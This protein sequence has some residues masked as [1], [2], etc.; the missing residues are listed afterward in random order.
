MSAESRVFVRAPSGDL[1]AEE[2]K[3]A[4]SAEG[5][6]A[7]PEG[8]HINDD[9]RCRGDYKSR[10]PSKIRHRAYGEAAFVVVM[11]VLAL[12]A[13][14]LTWRGVVADWLACEKC[15]HATLDRYAYVL[16]GGLLGGSLFGLKYIYKVLAHGF[17]NEDRIVWRVSSPLLSAGFA[18]AL[19]VLAQAGLFGFDMNDAHGPASFISLGFITGYFAD[20]ASRKMQEIADI[21]FGRANPRRDGGDGSS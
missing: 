21:V 11:L 2:L 18:F 10:Y 17:W 19:G 3:D 8:E 7:N 6:P 4:D 1:P 20:G 9:E 16:F 15:S 13:I 14:F 5:V 12:L